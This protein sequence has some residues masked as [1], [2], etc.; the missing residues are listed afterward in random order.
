MRDGGMLYEWR[1]AGAVQMPA[2]T[3]TSFSVGP[4][5]GM[6]TSS[7]VGG[8]SIAIGCTVQIAADARGMITEIRPTR[9]TIGRWQVSRCAEIFG[10]P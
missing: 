2:Q 8:G 10:S 6:A 4:G 9:D 1:E 5:G 7:T 3:I